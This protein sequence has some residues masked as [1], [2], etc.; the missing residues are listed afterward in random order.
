M[1]TRVG[2]EAVDVA[3]DDEVKI[4]EDPNLAGVDGGVQGREK[5]DGTVTGGEL[6]A[7]ARLYVDG[8]Y[9]DF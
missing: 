8:M 1:T 4:G 7:R 5:R 3:A 2:R 9:G 6:E